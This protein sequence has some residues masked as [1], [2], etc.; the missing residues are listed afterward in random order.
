M[1]LFIGLGNPG[2]SYQ[3]H[4]HNIGFMA[5]NAI[6]HAFSFGPFKSKFQGQVSEGKIGGEKVL[7]LKPET[8]MNRSGQSARE[9][10]DFYKLSPSD[11]FVFYDE[12]DLVP[13]KIKAR[14]GG[15]AAGHNGIRS[16][17]AHL[18]EDFHRV[19]LGVGH[20]GHKDLVHNFVLSN[21]SK[22]DG[23]WVIPVLEAVAKASPRLIERDIARFQT[24]VA[25]EL[26]PL[27]EESQE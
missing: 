11:I 23:E 18:G 25:L 26:T 19:R 4:R 13:G 22:A 7:I 2:Q 17:I 16:L 24:D 14:T 6:A 10:M 12:I 3:N 5:V 8:Y 1:I 27:K 9:A 21:F 15:G 20:P